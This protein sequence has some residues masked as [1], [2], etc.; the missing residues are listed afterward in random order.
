MKQILLTTIILFAA[1][2]AP[3]QQVIAPTGS[4]GGASG[5]QVHWTLA[6]PVTK[7]ISNTENT[8]TQGFHQTRLVITAI[9]DLIIENVNVSAFPNPATAILNIK[10]EQAGNHVYSYRIESLDGRCVVQNPAFS[11]NGQINVENLTTGVYILSVL[12]DNR[13]WIKTFKIVKQ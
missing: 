2:L 11:G 9:D 4:A 3:G 13:A 1:I 8:L 10:I 6:E 7:T 5:I 12:P